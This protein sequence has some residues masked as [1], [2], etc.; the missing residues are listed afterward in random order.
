LLRNYDCTTLPISQSTLNLLLLCDSH[1][2][3]CILKFVR[4]NNR[5]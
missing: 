3:M 5:L 2:T 1:E 4:A